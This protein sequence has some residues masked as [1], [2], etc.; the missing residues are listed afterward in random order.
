MH[1]HVQ[2]HPS[3]A[4]PAK[5]TASPQDSI[6]AREFHKAHFSAVSCFWS[7]SVCTSLLFVSTVLSAR[8][9][10]LLKSWLTSNFLLINRNYPVD[11][12]VWN[13]YFNPCKMFHVRNKSRCHYGQYDRTRKG[14]CWTSCLCGWYSWHVNSCGRKSRE[15]PWWRRLP[16]AEPFHL[17]T[18]PTTLYYTFHYFPDLLFYQFTG[19]VCSGRRALPRA[20]DSGSNAV[21]MSR[22]EK[23]GRHCSATA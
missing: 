18:D 14:Y 21:N 2:T 3:I 9:H 11:T 12:H 22:A 6:W 4:H 13:H 8:T 23:G 17:Q 16:P 5:G 19:C 15:A 10:V 7:T 20:L 1:Q